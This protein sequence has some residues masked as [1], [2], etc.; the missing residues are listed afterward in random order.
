MGL[1]KEL[2]RILEEEYTHFI[3]D[4]ELSIKISGCMNACGQHTIANIGFQGMTLKS[5]GL[6]A[7]ATQ[8]LI[9]GGVLGDGQGRF[10]DKLIKIPSKR[11]PQALRLI[12]DD[13]YEEGQTEESFLSYYDR[14]GKDYFYQL[15]KPLSD[16]DSLTQS[17]FI[18]WGN[19]EQYEKAIGIGECAG[20]TV[21]LVATLIMEAEEKM[22]QARSFL[23]QKQWADAIYAAYTGIIN[24]AKALLTSTD[25]KMRSQAAITRLFDQHFPD[26]EIPQGSL[27]AL[28]A[29]MRTQEPSA[30]F[31]RQFFGD[32]QSFLTLIIQTRHAQLQR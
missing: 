28:I 13:Y 23:E 11:T 16:S 24:S 32:A 10:A 17:D 6:V 19:H 8:I 20:V 2:E 30:E 5:N 1:A 15:L 31:A 3:L 26:L 12:L 14:Q 4:R 7:P 27:S 18:D 22:V 9:G 25:A 21:D 29:N